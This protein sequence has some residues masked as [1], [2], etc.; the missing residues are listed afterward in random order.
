MSAILLWYYHMASMDK[1]GVSST[2]RKSIDRMKS[3]LVLHRLEWFQ[4]RSLPQHH[5]RGRIHQFV[6][7]ETARNIV[8]KRPSHELFRRKIDPTYKSLANRFGAKSKRHPSCPCWKQLRFWNPAQI[9]KQAAVFREL[10][11]RWLREQNQ[12]C[13]SKIRVVWAKSRMKLFS[14]SPHQTTPLVNTTAT[15]HK[16]SKPTPTTSKI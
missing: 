11:Q 10:L 15:S 5:G 8:I 3:R 9:K 4:G 7:I 1:M 13:V 14:H 2:L 6:W 12:S 16:F